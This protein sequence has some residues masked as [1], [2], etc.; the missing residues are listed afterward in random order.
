MNIFGRRDA[1]ASP[2]QTTPT[3]FRFDTCA[4]DRRRRRRRGRP[5][6]STLSSLLPPLSLSLSSP[7]CATR[8]AGSRYPVSPREILKG[9]G[10]GEGGGGAVIQP[11]KRS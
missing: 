3:Y 5:R 2:I 9:R 7:R 4:R 10:E 11:D 8:S 1:S 6:P